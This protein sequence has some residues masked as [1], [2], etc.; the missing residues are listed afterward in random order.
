MKNYVAYYSIHSITKKEKRKSGNK[1]ESS[2]C[3]GI[4]DAKSF[5]SNM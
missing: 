4:S 2:D 5:E 1:N 3:N